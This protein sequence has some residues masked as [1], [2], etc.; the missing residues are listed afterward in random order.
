MTDRAA[1][2]LP[3]RDF[4]RTAAFYGPMGFDVGVRIDPPEHPYMIL[5]RGDLWLHFFG[6]EQEPET[7]DFMCYL[8][9]GDPDVWADQIRAINLPNA[10]IPR[11]M[12][13]EDKP[14]GMREFAV[15][16]PDGTLI[17]AGRD[18]TE[19]PHG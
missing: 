7:S 11:F 3:S 1:P 10:G 8:H 9:L 14:W 2:I 16:D 18:I 5:Y 4:D 17:R 15:I 12:D 13:I 19:P 6:H